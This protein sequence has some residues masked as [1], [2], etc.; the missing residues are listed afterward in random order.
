MQRAR[1]V[2][3]NCYD[4]RTWIAMREKSRVSRDHLCKMEGWVGENV[5]WKQSENSGTNDSD[6][7]VP[8]VISLP[9][10]IVTC[11]RNQYTVRNQ[12]P[13]SALFRCFPMLE[14]ITFPP[15]SS[16]GSIANLLE[17]Y[18]LQ[19]KVSLWFYVPLRLFFL[20]NPHKLRFQQFDTPCSFIMVHV[21][22]V[23]SPWLASSWNEDTGSS[24]FS[25]LGNKTTAGKREEMWSQWDIMIFAIVENGD[26]LLHYSVCV[27][28]V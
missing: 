10:N 5:G 21:H 3:L 1:H 14:L 9:K 26:I 11:Q 28:N 4:E 15:S 27:W 17:F 25:T 23:N 20:I 13:H 19:I 8:R 2:S 16:T 7:G 22:P 24:T 12:R 18:S 6:A